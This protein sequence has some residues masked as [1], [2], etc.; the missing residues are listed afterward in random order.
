MTTANPTRHQLWHALRHRDA[1]VSAGEIAR[2]IGGQNKV[3]SKRLSRW[4][5]AGLLEAIKPANDAGQNVPI[6]YIMPQNARRLIEPPA[7]GKHG[8]LGTY[9]SGRIAM[10]RVMRVLKSFDLVQL[11]MA[12]EV[13][14]GS[15]RVFVAT[16]LR[17]EVLRQV[18]RGHSATG[19]RSIYALNGTFGPKAPIISMDRTDRAITILDT[20]TGHARKISAHSP[21]LPLF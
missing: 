1:P 11:T 13:S 18:V 10:W 12:A 3:I 16:L 21:I 20:N 14:M 2:E 5:K 7:L 8:K 15:A 9:R 6:H 17:A 4:A 19:Q